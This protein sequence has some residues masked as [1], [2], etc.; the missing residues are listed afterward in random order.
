MK[1]FLL[2]VAVIIVT[3]LSF[4]AC[5]GQKTEKAVE[6][7]P[8]EQVEPAVEA[9]DSVIVSSEEAEPQAETPAEAA[10]E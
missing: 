3:G 2:I 4:A 8:Q 10:K 7:V 6:V 1:K 9:V 5:S